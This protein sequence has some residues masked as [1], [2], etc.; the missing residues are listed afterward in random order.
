MSEL[1]KAY[2]DVKHGQIHY[3]EAGEGAPLLLIGETPRGYRFFHKL[4]PLL[5]PHFRA[6]AIDPAGARQLASAS[7]TDVHTSDGRMPRGLS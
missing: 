7:E 4:V 6:I 3:V 5:A 2:A 1:R